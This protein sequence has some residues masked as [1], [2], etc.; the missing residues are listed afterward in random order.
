M[1]AA[2]S[3]AVVKN[4]S[5]AASMAR[6][7]LMTTPPAASWRARQ[8][9]RKTT[10]SKEPG[11]IVRTRRASKSERLRPAVWTEVRDP[12]SEVRETDA[13]ISLKGKTTISWSAAAARERSRA[14][15]ESGEAR[16]AKRKEG[17]GV[18]IRARARMVLSHRSGAEP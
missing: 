12:R 5:T 3:L 14:Y 6:A 17:L 16:T 1:P 10:C 8:S 11:G 4:L 9:M 2:W 18:G 15:H 13:E 7:G